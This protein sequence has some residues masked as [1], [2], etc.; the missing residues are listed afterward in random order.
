MNI[1]LHNLFIFRVE[2]AQ[3]YNDNI[4]VPTKLLHEFF[5]MATKNIEYRQTQYNIVTS[6]EI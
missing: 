4:N 1:Q 2:N 3:Q 6:M 5:T